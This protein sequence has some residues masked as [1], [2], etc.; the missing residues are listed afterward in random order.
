METYEFSHAFTLGTLLISPVHVRIEVLSPV[1]AAHRH[2]N[3]SYEIH[4]AAKGRGTVTIDGQAR[5]VTADTLYVTGPGV[6]HAQ[7]SPRA[8]PI[9][10]YCLPR[11][12]PNGLPRGRSLR[13][14]RGH[15]LLDGQGRRQGV[16]AAGAAH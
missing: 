11:L 10:E 3:T 16:P 1:I 15:G 2:S 9:M 5:D 4:Y 12:P 13:P 8:D 6:S 7:V 14:V